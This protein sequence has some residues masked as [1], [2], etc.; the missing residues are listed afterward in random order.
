MRFKMKNGSFQTP[1]GP[2]FRP[3][4]FFA[5]I[6]LFQMFLPCYYGS[7]ISHDSSCFLQDSFETE[8][9]KNE[10]HQPHKTSLLVLREALKREMKI[11]GMK[12]YTLDLEA[13]LKVAKGVSSL[14][15]R[16]N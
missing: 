11:T 7:Q 9:F 3:L 8:W 10:D 5:M 14:M 4:M 1:L 13:F 6:T 2:E 16:I 12:I 15:V